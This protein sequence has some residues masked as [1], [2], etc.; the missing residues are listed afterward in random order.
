MRGNAAKAE[1]VL[2]WKPTVGFE[3]L[4]DLMLKN[5]LNIEANS[6]V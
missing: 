1:N 5:D 2:G 6:D 4:V 3:N